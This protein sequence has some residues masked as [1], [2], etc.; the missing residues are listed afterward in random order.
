MFEQFDVGDALQKSTVD[1]DIDIDIDVQSAKQPLE[2]VFSSAAAAA[3][4]TRAAA[5][6]CT[7]I[8]KRVSVLFRQVWL[9]LIAD[10]RLQVKL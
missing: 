10:E 5:A 7:K 2:T 8:E 3:S 4:P 1:I 6:A 9:I